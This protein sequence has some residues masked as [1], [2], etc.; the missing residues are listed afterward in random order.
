MSYI[1]NSLR[2]QSFKGKSVGNGQCVAFVHGAV[3]IPPT[4]LWHRGLPVKG[5]LSL[6]IGTVI[7][8][9]DSSGHYGN[10][11]NGTSH[12]AIYMGQNGLGI[13]VLDQWDHRGAIQP[14]HERTI[15]FHNGL[16]SKVDDGDQYYV[17]E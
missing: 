8:T 16:R 12:T 10:H 2:A 6:P 3:N 11:T 4:V 17:V 9:F 14:V 15:G 7:A 5:D 1:A 13:Q